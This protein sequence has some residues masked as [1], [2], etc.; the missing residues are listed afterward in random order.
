MTTIDDIITDILKAEGWDTYTNDPVDRGGPTKWGITQKAW[1]EYVGHAAPIDEIKAITEHQARIFYENMY[2][3]AP[4]FDMLPPLLMPMVVD[5]G[6]NHGI[7][8]ASKWVQKAVGAKQ[9][10]VLGPK[11]LDAVTSTNLLAIYQRVAAYRFQLYGKIVSGDHSQAKY[12][13]GWNNRGSKWLFR[14]ADYLAGD[15]T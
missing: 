12:A 3:K 6:V 1:S 8:A 10:G 11:T 14:L 15:D 2:I 13:H 9:D 7:R 5:C 4:K